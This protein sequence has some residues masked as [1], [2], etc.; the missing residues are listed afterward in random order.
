MTDSRPRV[1]SRQPRF[2]PRA[3]GSRSKH[4]L[5]NQG[6][7]ELKRAPSSTPGIPRF[8]QAVVAALPAPRF[9]GMSVGCPAHDAA[10]VGDPTSAFGTLS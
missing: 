10:G 8:G 6:L 4:V 5:D 2:Y 3:S 1:L 7:K 9:D